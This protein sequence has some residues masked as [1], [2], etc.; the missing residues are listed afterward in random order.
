MM[1]PTKQLIYEIDQVL[2]GSCEQREIDDIMAQAE[3]YRF[4]MRVTGCERVIND[5]SR[6][7]LLKFRGFLSGYV[8]ANSQSQVPITNNNIATASASVEVSLSQTMA[9]MWSLPDEVAT[10]DQK[11]EMSQLLDEL[12]KSKGKGRDRV[13]E[14]AKAIGDYVFDKCIEAAPTVLPLVTQAIQNFM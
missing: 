5:R 8:T 7:G 10:Q 11:A 9:A 2:A 14:A 12:E 1:D 6:E 13:R 3:G 4:P